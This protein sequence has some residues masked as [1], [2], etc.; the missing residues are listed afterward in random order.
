MA[1]DAASEATPA[2]ATE[3]PLFGY[4]VQALGGVWLPG[5]IGVIAIGL[6]ACNGEVLLQVAGNRLLVLGV[7]ADY[8]GNLGFER[9]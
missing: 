5:V 8:G 1:D 3:R 4:L 7:L 9:R 6:A 2:D